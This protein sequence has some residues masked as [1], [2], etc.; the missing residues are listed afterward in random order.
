MGVCGTC[1]FERF[2]QSWF[3]K[4]KLKYT[5]CESKFKK[6]KYCNTNST[7][8]TLSFEIQHLYKK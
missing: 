3:S 5:Y 7:Q 4:I 8:I 2:L 1:V 6:K